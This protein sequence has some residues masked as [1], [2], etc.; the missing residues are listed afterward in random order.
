M[1]RLEKAFELFD[2]YNKQDPNIFEWEGKMYPA[3]YFYGLQLYNW[4]KKLDGEASETLLLA[5]RSA[6]IGRWKSPREN[7]PM[8]KPGYYKWRTELSKFHAET[9]GSLMQEAGYTEAEI[10]AVQSIIR[11]E[12]LRT[13]YEVQIM[14]DALCL[15][16]LQFQY[17]EF[18]AKHDDE[19]VIRILQKSWGKMNEQGRSAALTLQFSE[20]GKDLINKALA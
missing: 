13:N 6:H 2:N 9:A 17:D 8:G 12:Q 11:K 15:V 20:K 4:V 18:I 16:F 5:A 10:L 19:K 1:S 3:E 7:Y 14:E